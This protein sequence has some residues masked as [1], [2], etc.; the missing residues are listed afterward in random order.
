MARGRARVQSLTL[1]LY[2]YGNKIQPSRHSRESFGA[3]YNGKSFASEL[4]LGISTEKGAPM[5][6][7]GFLSF[8]ALPLLVA[9]T[10]LHEQAEEYYQAGDY[11]AAEAVNQSILR[12]DPADPIAAEHLR[13]TRQKLIER[14]LIEARQLRL[15]NSLEE[16]HS[17]LRRVVRDEKEWNL[18]PSGAAFS[19]Q[20]EEV[21]YLYE[22]LQEQVQLLKKDK[23]FLKLKLLLN[24]NHELLV[25]S[26][27][28]Q[29]FQHMVADVDA[30]G[31]K[32]CLEI[33]PVMTGYFSKDFWNHYC[34]FWGQEIKNNPSMTLTGGFGNIVLKGQIADMPPDVLSVFSDALLQGL[35]SS[36]LYQ[37]DG[38]TLVVNISGR[39]HSAYSEEKSVG[40]HS[41]DE[42][43]PYQVQETVTYIEKEPE[44]SYKVVKDPVTQKD[45]Y[46]PVTTYRDVTKYREETVTKYRK[47]A[48]TLTYPKTD[49]NVDYALN[50][51]FSF[52]LDG[53]KYSIPIN[54]KMHISDSYHEV[55]NPR[56]G[57]SV[58]P[59]KIPTEIYWLKEQ[60]SD[61]E[62]NTR[63]E[64]KDS[65]ANK[66]CNFKTP[67]LRSSQTEVVLK[68][69]AGVGDSRGVVDSWSNEA[70]QMSYND[71]RKA[72]GI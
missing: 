68:C 9:C 67:P 63:H 70:F 51:Q 52:T 42:E 15:S 31:A 59:Q 26:Q 23:K 47:E 10:S 38:R 72:I 2:R 50:S 37:A 28:N 21:E 54:E 19:A 4:N 5:R 53:V 57:L 35:K 71:L 64:V 65:W 33:R 43:V 14:N 18:S 29:S 12:Q 69:A 40:I 22:W 39:F 62:K 60:S 16:S 8:F 44:T 30:G 66:Y 20:T 45:E 41:Y 3:K 11:A 25:H 49:F 6:T 27:W 13:K 56:I 1:R 46:K 7:L 48:R 55:S 17:K 34:V 58:R 24:E 36:P 61:L 32:H